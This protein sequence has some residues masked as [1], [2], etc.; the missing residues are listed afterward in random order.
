MVVDYPISW[1]LLLGLKPNG[2]TKKLATGPHPIAAGGC[3]PQIA[4]VFEKVCQCIPALNI[5]RKTVGVHQKGQ[6]E[7]LPL[8]NP[9]VTGFQPIT[10]QIARG[11]LPVESILAGF[12]WLNLRQVPA[13]VFRAFALQPFGSSTT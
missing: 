5:R 9:K 8:A 2:K 10:A 1:W 7:E 13:R 11:R 3:P 6:R 12:T 4:Q